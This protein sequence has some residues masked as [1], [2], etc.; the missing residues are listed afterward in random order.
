MTT[1]DRSPHVVILGAG[2]GGLAAARGLRRAPVRITI[3][4][5]SN[6]HLFQPLLYQVATAALSP[7]DIA[8]PIRRIFRHQSNVAVMLAEATAI[9]LDRETGRACRRRGRFRHSDRGDGRDPRLFRPRRLGRTRPRPQI[10]ARRITDPAARSYGLRG[11]RAR[12]R[13]L[14]PAGLD[15][16]CDRGRRPDGRRAG[17]NARRSLAAD[18]GARLPPHQHGVGPGHPGRSHARGSWALI[19]KTFRRRLASSSKSWA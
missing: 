12:D 10:A 3:I 5:R 16:V 14:P 4:D 11:R 18:P 17:R 7:A 15:D 1:A 6:H 9:N 2:F 8:A 13:R 19:P